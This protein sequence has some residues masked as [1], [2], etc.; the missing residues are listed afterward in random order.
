MEFRDYYQIMG[1]ARDATQDDIKRAYRKLARKYHPDVSK[2]PDAEARF[3]EVGEAYEVL[4]DPEKR[5]A[6]DRLGANWKSGQEF[7]PPPDWN[8]GFE[9]SGGGPAGAGGGADFSDFFET[10]FGRGFSAG[11]QR[12]GSFAMQGENRHARVLIDLD[13]A[14]GGATRTITLRIPA[15]DDQ[16]RMADARAHAQR[17]DSAWH[18]A[19]PADPPRRPGRAG[20]R[21]RQG[22]R[23][24]P[25]GRVPAASAV[26]GRGTR[27]VSRSAVGS[28]GSSAR[29]GGQGARRRAGPSNSRFRRTQAPAGRCG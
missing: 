5:A 16:G 28:V 18:S 29:R 23:P 3:K 27:R 12:A 24:V 21:R 17:Q 26:S 1:V 11:R 22:G 15:V 4:K 14:Y 8:A 19:R 6:Y 10:L 13:D 20:H 2:V 9:F 25:G 7:R